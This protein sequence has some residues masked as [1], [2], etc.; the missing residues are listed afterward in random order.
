MKQELQIVQSKFLQTQGLLDPRGCFAD[1]E[2]KN[3]LGEA[4]FL[5]E[6]HSSK[7]TRVL[8]QASTQFGISP[9]T[10]VLPTDLCQMLQPSQISSLL[11]YLC[12]NQLHLFSQFLW[13]ER[14]LRGPT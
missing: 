6:I 14:G 8:P 12:Y 5:A 13:M 4:Q 1:T 11:P 10:A 2:E 9:T 3:A 7:T